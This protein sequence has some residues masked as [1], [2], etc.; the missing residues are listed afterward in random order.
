MWHVGMD[1]LIALRGILYSGREGK[2]NCFIEFELLILCFSK[3][4]FMGEHL[5]FEY[6][7]EEL[8]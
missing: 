2:E 4:N 7:I 8:I 3:L 5:L 6:F 1:F